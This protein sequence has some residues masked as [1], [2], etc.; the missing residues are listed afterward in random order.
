M[1]L[2]ELQRTIQDGEER[3]LAIVAISYDPVS[4]L[5]GF[6]DKHGITYPL[7]SDEGSHV[8]TELG[9]LNTNIAAEREHWGKPMTK[10]HVGLPYPGTFLLDADGMIT[11]KIFEKS[12]RVRPSGSL[13]LER[14][15]S[16][17]DEMP[18]RAAQS[19]TD[20]VA[21]A[22][23]TDEP[24]FFPNQLQQLRI[25]LAIGDGLHIYVPPVPDGYNPLRVDVEGPA[26]LLTRTPELPVGH[27]LT[28]DIL[29]ETF[30]VADGTVD[31]SIPFYVR[32]DVVDSSVPYHVRYSSPDI[33]AR[34]SIHFQACTD[35]TCYLP[36]TVTVP[37]TIIAD[38]AEA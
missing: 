6:A 28:I 32:D 22:V 7:L 13:L 37:I 18:G 26:H 9:L 15:G 23:W 10:R 4:T 2:V 38:T 8:I 25:R 27:P 34:V 1:Q 36:Q 14:L 24:A 16:V 29:G 5:G 21:V 20:G 3:D 12:H 31:V 30:T 33:E 19:A 35:E 17:E 11:E